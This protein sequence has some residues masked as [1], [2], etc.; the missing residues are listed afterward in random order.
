MTNSADN[1]QADG[2]HK[3]FARLKLNGHADSLPA[4]F[5]CP[6]EVPRTEGLANVL[7]IAASFELVKIRSLKGML[8]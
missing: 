6:L 3:F 4:I 7:G 8:E 1:F 5:G 2:T